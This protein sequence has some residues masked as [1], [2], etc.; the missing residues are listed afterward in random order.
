MTEGKDT[1]VS[2]SCT[3]MLGYLGKRAKDFRNN[4]KREELTITVTERG[5]FDVVTR[6]RKMGKNRQNNADRL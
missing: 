3:Y 4:R 2:D 5:C 1:S 6:N